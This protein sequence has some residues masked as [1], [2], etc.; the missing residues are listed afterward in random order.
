MPHTPA[1]AVTPAAYRDAVTKILPAA[2]DLR[3]ELADKLDVLLKEGR[4][5]HLQS[6]I[7]RMALNVSCRVREG[8]VKLDE[9]SDL[10][11]LLTLNAFIY[12]ARRLRTY[13]GECSVTKNEALLKDLF[14]KLAH[15]DDGKTLPF[16]EF[17]ARVEREV[18]GIVITAHPTFTVSEELTRALATLAVGKTEVG[19]TLSP[20]DLDELVRI[21]AERPHG[22]TQ[23]ITLM[24]EQRFAL[25]AIANIRKALRRI[26]AVVF[27][28]AREFYP[29][30]WQTLTPRLLTVASWVGYDLDGRADIRWS[31]TLSMRMGVEKL[32]VQSYLESLDTLGGRGEIAQAKVL[33]QGA[34]EQL[35]ADMARLDC[36]P[37]NVDE[38]GPFSRALA[39]SLEGR[40]VSVARVTELL[41]R[42]ID[43]DG[44]AAADA[45]V[46]RAEMA[47]FGL[48]F[49][50]THM[51]INATQLTNAIRHDID[52]TTSPEDPAN[53]RRYLVEISKLLDGVKPVTINFGS[54]M[55]ERTTAKRVFMLVAQFIKYVDNNEPVRFLIAECNT[56]FTVLTA[57]YFAKL[58][59]VADKIDISPLFETGVA[60]D[61]GHEI[62][63]ELLKNKTYVEYVKI[64]GRLCIQT[65]FSDAGRYIGQVPASLAIERIRIKLAKRIQS[66]GLKGVDLLIFDTHGESMG[67][68]AH[69]VSF[70]DRLDYTYPPFARQK[71]K[72]AGINVKQEVSFQ[73]GDGY[74]YFSHPDLAFATVCR[75]IEHALT[76]DEKPAVS[77]MF[78][79]DTDY[80][81]DYFMTVKGFN[82][83][84]MDNPNYAATLNL[85]GTNLLYSTGSRRVK[86]QH[87]GGAQ[88]D[89]EHPSQVRAIPH[90][91]IL[92]QLGYFSNTI[93]G[94]GKA[95]AK[96]S[97]RFT[98]IFKLSDRCRRFIAMVANG[99]HL[100]NLDALHG[101]VSLFDPAIWLRRA[102]IE[103]NAERAE[104]MQKLSNIL[105]HSARHEKVNRVYRIF[106][107][108]TRYL[109]HGLKS[110]DAKSMLPQIV[111]E[112]YPDLLLLHAVRIALI[113]EIFL[114]ASRVPKF[115]DRHDTSSDDVINE[116]LNLDVDHALSVLR[117]AF[118]VSGVS[119]AAKEFGEEATYRT[120]VEH[121]YEKEHRE[122]FQP[123]ED[124]Y[125]LVRK[126]SSAVAHMSGA[127]G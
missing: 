29:D 102:S 84:L 99:R 54:I 48:A 107:N 65:G 123:L 100:S 14:T 97:D 112:C 58:F 121:G 122:L 9:V 44:D 92:Q 18:F 114:L 45:A 24:D 109:D 26:Y 1:D 110:V 38:V 79:E 76:G 52:I 37:D 27:Q 42:A 64:R 28:V 56:P 23:S 83:R 91:A 60:L 120:D 82:E 81:L 8:E 10:V 59:G 78:Y 103:E 90:N 6:P 30:A 95:I 116:L 41:T 7:R 50:H 35:D 51:R 15:G 63:A 66:S 106:L 94:H 13:V 22:S 61:Q 43:A 57:L 2:C 19:V 98:E 126:I 4:E 93:S 119:A 3:D 72:E 17:K 5:N 75:L 125:D 31:D 111:D 105:R 89:L 34:L 20:E 21:A 53:R 46:L 62:V 117:K 11:R 70:A 86:R 16:T 80:S 124:Y 77:D 71:F 25:M 115:S 85:L 47:N 127:V 101:Y 73:G 74:V 68:G 104:Q 113:H 87:E 39:E 67:R 49:A 40:L 69:P 12:R 118:P 108:D 96:D 33:L 32:A 88:V 36:D 55:N